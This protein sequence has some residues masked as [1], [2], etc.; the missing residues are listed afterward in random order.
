MIKKDYKSIMFEYLLFID[1]RHHGS[2][3]NCYGNYQLLFL[4]TSSFAKVNVF[5][6]TVI[7]WAQS[8]FHFTW[9]L[10]ESIQVCMHAAHLVRIMALNSIPIRDL[11]SHS[12]NSLFRCVTECIEKTKTVWL[13]FCKTHFEW[14]F[15]SRYR[16]ERIWSVT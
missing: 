11:F 8:S 4:V 7:W 16:Q 14:H 13:F 12:T 6:L 3:P 10:S 1:D 9:A 2:S 5:L 15:L